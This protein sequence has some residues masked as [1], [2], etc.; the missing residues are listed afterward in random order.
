MVITDS[1]AEVP[2]RLSPASPIGKPGKPLSVSTG[3]IPSNRI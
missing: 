3:K 1:E 2:D